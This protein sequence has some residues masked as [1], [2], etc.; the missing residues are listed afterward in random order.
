MYTQTIIYLL[1]V[2]LCVVRQLKCK[3]KI[4]VMVMLDT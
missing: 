4:P 2:I 3:M 1:D